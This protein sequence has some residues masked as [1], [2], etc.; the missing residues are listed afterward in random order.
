MLSSR[1]SA[2]DGPA[3]SDEAQRDVSETARLQAAIDREARSTDQML[4][5]HPTASEDDYPRWGA[6]E[7]RELNRQL[8]ALGKGVAC[9]WSRNEGELPLRAELATLLSFAKTLHVDAE[10]WRAAL[11]GG[12]EERE[13]ELARQEAA[14]RA[15]Q[16]KLAAAR[17]ALERVRDALQSQIDEA[18]ARL[19]DD[20]G[21][22][23]RRTMPVLTLGEDITVSSVTV[24]ARKRRFRAEKRWLVTLDDAQT[25]VE[26]RRSSRRAP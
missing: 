13:R 21:G 7:H 25:S 24:V 16:A 4:N 15:E 26:V 2:R 5:D 10:A 11:A 6:A 14:A 17:E 18:A 22:A 19:V 9:A 1:L 12:L 3:L 8:A 23:Q 20:N